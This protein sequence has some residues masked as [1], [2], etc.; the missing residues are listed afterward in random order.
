M[1]RASRNF[2]A[3]TRRFGR[4]AEEKSRNEIAY[5]V[6]VR[7]KK[8][9]LTLPLREFPESPRLRVEIPASYV[10]PP[11]AAV[12]DF[13]VVLSEPRHARRR[14]PAALQRG[15]PFQP[16]LGFFQSRAATRRV[17]ARPHRGRL[18]QP[19]ARR[20]GRRARPFRRRVPRPF[21]ALRRRRQPSARLRG[22]SAR[23]GQGADAAHAPFPAAMAAA[24]RLPREPSIWDR[25]RCCNP[26]AGWPTAATRK[27]ASGWTI[28]KTLSGS[29]AATPS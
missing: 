8:F 17:H 14:F 11:A 9:P 26:I 18:E 20:L 29:I 15:I 16:R 7:Q 21:C 1:A 3:E 13:A 4:R 2:N 24:A 5:R 23:R 27:P 22:Q 19:A 12:Q 6:T 28:W 10:F 25:R